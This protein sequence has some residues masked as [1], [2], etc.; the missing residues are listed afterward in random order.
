[1]WLHIRKV[2]AEQFTNA[3][4]RQVFRDI[5]MLTAAIVPAPRIALGVFVG[6]DRPLRLHHGARDDVFGGD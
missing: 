6:H 4:N 2:A 3:L 5:N 1:M